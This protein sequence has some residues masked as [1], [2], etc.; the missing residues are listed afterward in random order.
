MVP[1]AVAVINEEAAV[2]FISVGVP[3][4]VKLNNDGILSTKANKE[5]LKNILCAL[6]WYDCPPPILC[7]PW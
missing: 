3:V 1:E 7:P 2:A 6:I 4:I 5:K